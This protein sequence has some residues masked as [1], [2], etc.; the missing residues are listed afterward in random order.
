MTRD[1][2]HKLLGLTASADP[3]SIGQKYADLKAGLAAAQAR[4]PTA[5]L[6]AK[7]QQAMNQ[8]DEAFRVA[9]APAPN[10]P[11]IPLPP[12]SNAS[13]TFKINEASS[14]EVSAL[15]YI[16]NQA[17]KDFGPF[18]KMELKA[19]FLSGEFTYDKVVRREYSQQWQVLY[20]ILEEAAA[21]KPPPLSGACPQ[22]GAETV[23]D[24]G[25]T[26]PHWAVS[27]ILGVIMYNII[28]LGFDLPRV[29]GLIAVVFLWILVPLL[30]SS[31][32]HKCTTCGHSWSKAQ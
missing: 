1:E 25:R 21:A 27:S 29:V 14:E 4:S 7:H 17:G 6:K 24:G 20:A 19:K 30:F 23:E 15:Y 13:S 10:H 8:L 26:A 11:E 9:I 28:H 22:C 31:A 16:Y 32:K 3:A 2:A 12:N 5:G 18:T